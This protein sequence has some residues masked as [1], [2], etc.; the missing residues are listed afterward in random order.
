MI[1]A[2]HAIKDENGVGYRMAYKVLRAQ[3]LDVA[4][5][6][7]RLIMILIRDDVESPILFPKEKDHVVS[8]WEAIGDCPESE[9]AQYAPWKYE[10][11]K[12]VP[13]GGYW[14]H[15]DIDTQKMYLKGSFHL[16]GGKTGMA[17]RLSWDEPSL[18][19]TCNPAQKQTERCHPIETRPLSV[20]EYA[21]V[22]TFPDNWNFFGGMT[23]AYKQIGNAVPVNMAFHL[24]KAVKMML[25]GGNVDENLFDIV[26]PLDR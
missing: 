1:D 22:Q 13:A 15:L 17:R 16:T 18:T 11:M 6:R 10:V 23:A 19:L 26:A 24:G 14:K 20:R 9:G 25:E 12:K 7:E 3:Y 21:R 8:L 2:V 4:Q 5:K